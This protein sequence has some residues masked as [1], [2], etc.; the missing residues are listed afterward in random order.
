MNRITRVPVSTTQSTAGYSMIEILIVVAIIGIL[1][2]IGAVSF[3]SQLKAS[4]IGSATSIINANLTQARQMAIAMRQSRRVAIDIGELDGFSNNNLSG[5]RTAVPSIWIEGKR[6]DQFSFSENAHCLGPRDQTTPNAFIIGD[7]S[8][9]PDG[10]TIASLGR[11]ILGPNTPSILYIEFNS[12]GQAT[13][14][15]FEGRENSENLATLQE[16][17]LHIVQD[18]E[19]FNYGGSDMGYVDAMNNAN[20]TRLNFESGEYANERLKV[21]TI[22]IVRLTGKTRVYRHAIFGGWP[23]DEM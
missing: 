14:A 11:Q 16:L 21:N 2:G 13:K 22:E 23:S 5:Y 19:F 18:N 8:N 20:A 15:Y 3:Q 1:A 10:I 12:R 17:A 6:C 7:P 4:R 9:L